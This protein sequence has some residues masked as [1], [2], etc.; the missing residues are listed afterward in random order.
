MTYAIIFYEGDD[1]LT[2]RSCLT[3]GLLC[4]IVKVHYYELHQSEN[5]SK[6]EI[7]KTGDYNP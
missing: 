2:S 5:P 7:M 3:L 6:S 1:M 4:S